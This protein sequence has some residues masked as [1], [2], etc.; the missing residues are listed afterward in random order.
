MGKFHKLPQRQNDLRFLLLK[1][2]RPSAEYSYGKRNTLYP[3]RAA[4]FVS[5]VLYLLLSIQIFKLHKNSLP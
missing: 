1:E 5:I 3:I 4:Y 2:P